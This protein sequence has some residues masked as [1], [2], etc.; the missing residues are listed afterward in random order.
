MKS[1][2]CQFIKN[3]SFLKKFSDKSLKDILIASNIKCVKRGEILFLQGDK[4]NKLYIILNGSFK[5]FNETISGY[6]SVR[7]LLS[8]GDFFGESSLC[9]NSSYNYGAECTKNSQVLEINKDA[10]LKSMQEDG[11]MGNIFLQELLESYLRFEVQKEYLSIMSA[12]QRIGWYLMT[13]L[14][15]YKF[16]NNSFSL[17]H[18]KS[19]IATYLGMK[20]ETF[21]RS[22]KKL[23]ELDVLVN[24]AEITVKDYDKLYKFC[25]EV[26]ELG[27]L[28]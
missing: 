19:H 1:N 25:F 17:M 12:P 10:I 9:A 13:L 15:T 5:L 16:K 28:H 18:E 4:A 24:G 23:K 21:S 7:K 20:P 22:I 11:A 27:A 14:S 3:V 8:N 6:E 2:L 26:E